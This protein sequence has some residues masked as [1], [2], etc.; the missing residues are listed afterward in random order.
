MQ[1][2][3]TRSIKA[4]F[5]ETTTSKNEEQLSKVS[6]EPAIVQ[7]GK[8]SNSLIQVGRDYIRYLQI[9]FEGGNWTPILVNVACLGLIFYGLASATRSAVSYAT[10][11]QETEGLC[12]PRMQKLALAFSREVALNNA[13][14]PADQRQSILDISDF[15]GPQGKQGECGLQG[16]KGDVGL[17][18]NLGSPGEKGDRGLQGS[19]GLKGE[20]G[21]HGLQGIPW[22]QGFQG[23]RGLTGPQGRTGARGACGPQGARGRQGDR[24]PQALRQPLGD[25]RESPVTILE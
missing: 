6:I 17:Q 2:K 14:L 1:I 5:Q 9:N 24:G 18:G 25:N 22:I 10:N 7:E 13:E 11:L 12:S 23:D 8:A 4:L 3:F 16:I 15:Q 21:D 20:K 19:Q